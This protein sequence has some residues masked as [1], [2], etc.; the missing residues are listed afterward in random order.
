MKLKTFAAALAATTIAGSAFAADLPARKMAPAYVAPAP[1]FTWTGFYVGVNA[2]YA[3]GDNKFNSS[4]GNVGLAD[5]VTFFS[6]SS[7]SAKGNSFTGGGTVGFNY[8]MGMFVAGV[9]G[10]LGYL[11]TLGTANRAGVATTGVLEASQTASGSKGLFGTV[12]GRL[13][14]AFNQF[15]I[16][17]TGGLAFGNTQLSQVMVLSN[18]NFWLG[19]ASS[20]KTGWTA[21]AG[22]EYA[23]SPNWSAKI[24]YLHVDLGT[25]NIAMFSPTAGNFYSVRSTNRADMVRAGVN[26]KFGWGGAAPVVAKY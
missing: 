17:G 2:G 25:R 11:N 7:G 5:P 24:E 10:D 14:V 16:Y 1:I 3:W 23:F 9:E 19:S 12:R 6:V 21:G 15:L 18:G 8:Q 26:Y 13:G 4:Q 22:V 20:G